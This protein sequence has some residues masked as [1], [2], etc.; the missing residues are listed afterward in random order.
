MQEKK[1]EKSLGVSDFSFPFSVFR[2]PLTLGALGRKRLLRGYALFI[3]HF[4]RMFGKL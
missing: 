1:I 2:F 4:S 3:L